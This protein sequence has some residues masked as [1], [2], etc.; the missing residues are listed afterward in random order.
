M[1][2][3]HCVCF[4]DI[5]ETELKIHINKYSKFGIAFNKSFL[6]GKGVNPILYIEENSIIYKNDF[7]SLGKYNS[8]NREDY[9]QEFCSKTIFYF[10]QKYWINCKDDVERQDTTEILDFLINLFGHLKIWNN[11]LEEH[12]PNNYYFEREWRASNNIDFQLSDVLVI[13]IPKD[14]ENKFKLNFPE[15]MGKLKF[16][17]DIEEGV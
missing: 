4:A 8:I 17:E 12:D 6:I 14:Y 5:P 1:F 15:Y 11:N 10:I 2:N 9:Y 7:S 3:P 13:I 16:A